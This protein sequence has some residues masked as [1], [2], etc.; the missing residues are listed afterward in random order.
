MSGVRDAF[1]ALHTG[2]VAVNAAD[3]AA[4]Y[5]ARDREHWARNLEAR[6]CGFMPRMSNRQEWRDVLNAP[7]LHG[8]SVA[9]CLTTAR[10]VNIPVF[11]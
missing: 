4:Q 2:R 11:M 7:E 8:R 5:A 10:R 3:R 6:T 1:R 9:F